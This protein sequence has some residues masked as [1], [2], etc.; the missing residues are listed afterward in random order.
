MRRREIPTIQAGD[1]G[2]RGLARFQGGSDLFLRVKFLVKSPFPDTFP[3]P[4]RCRCSTSGRVIK[5][6]QCRKAY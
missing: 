4:G 2:I 5:K 6:E 3:P 1:S